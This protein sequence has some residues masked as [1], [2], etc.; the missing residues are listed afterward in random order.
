[1]FFGSYEF[2]IDDKGRTVIPSK[3]R[4][5]LG[6]KAY[7]IKGF[8]GCIALYKDEDFQK[9]IERYSHLPYEDEKA[10]LHLRVLASSTEE[11]KVDNQGRLQIP[12]RILAKYNIGKEIT[13]N[14]VFD[15]I[16]IWDR[17]SYNQY[18]ADNEDQ[19]ETNAANLL[20]YEK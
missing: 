4:D 18:L 14:G 16:E 13:I 20:N 2:P 17:A 3:F 1:M 12:A 8:E 15:H 5:E 7:L 11:V 6:Y 10:R 9:L 19:F